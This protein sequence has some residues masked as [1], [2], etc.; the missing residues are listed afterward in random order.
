MRTAGILALL[1]CLL[2]AIAPA[3]TISYVGN[4]ETDCD[5][6]CDNLG[7]EGDY[8]QF[9][10][11][12]ESFTLAAPS[13]VV[14]VSFS[15]GGGTNGNG[16]LIAAGGFEP[17]LSL[18]DSAGNFL[19]STYFGETCPAG[20]ALYQGF[21]YDVK[22]DMGT[23][24]EGTYQIAISAYMNMSF[25]ENNGPPLTL[26]DGFTGLGN[27]WPGEDLHY[28]FDVIIRDGGGPEIPEPST[29]LLAAAGLACLR[30]FKPAR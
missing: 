9:A 16:A 14:A 5:Y 24:A 25:A 3:A 18:F 10:V 6:G 29:W 26:A 12:L 19:A 23:L 30:L 27:L 7:T 1:F 15:Y 11:A 4:L 17:Y 8:A 21:C 20:A 28:A 22:L 2:I 13:S